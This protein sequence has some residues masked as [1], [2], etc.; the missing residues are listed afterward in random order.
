MDTIIRYPG[1]TKR[2]EAKV[3][4]IQIPDLWHVVMYLK[5]QAKNKDLTIAEKAFLTISADNILDTWH[6]AHNFKDNIIAD[7]HGIKL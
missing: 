6:L 1:G 7:N 5:D 4:S 3:E 2:H